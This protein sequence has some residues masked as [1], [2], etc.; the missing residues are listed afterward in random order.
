MRQKAGALDVKSS[1][2][3]LCRLT[4]AEYTTLHC[5]SSCV[6][7]SSCAA[8]AFTTLA[9][10]ATIA[11]RVHNESLV[12]SWNARL[13]FRNSQETVTGT[14]TITRWLAPVAVD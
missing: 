4:R 3:G 8:L 9:A 5:C 14:L 12:S 6:R 7:D 10:S 11:P 2:L 13:C 1:R